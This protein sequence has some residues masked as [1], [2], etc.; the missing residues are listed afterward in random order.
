M[1]QSKV[2]YLRNAK[3]PIETPF[4]EKAWFKA[5][6]R[7][8]NAFIGGIPPLRRYVAKSIPYLSGR[9]PKLYREGKYIEALEL[10]LLGITKCAKNNVMN[11]W[12]WWSFMSYAVYCAYNLDNTNI[13][14]RLMTISE[15]GPEPIE[16][17]KVSYC[18]C[19][20]SHLKYT[21]EDYDSAIR[22]AELANKADDD[23]GEAYYLLGYYDLFINEKDPVDLFSAAIE[24]D[25]KIL[26][27]IVH[28]PSLKEFPGIIEEL[29]K[30]H[31]ITP[32]SP[33]E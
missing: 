11:H 9:V 31:V 26:S 25:P 13:M 15:K 27:R 23:S 30:L 17:S 32:K 29:K 16:D 7:L 12:W 21:Q 22:F 20:F 10:S 19:H 2:V 8:I 5:L 28:H 18:Y 4:C 6:S 24:R 14:N 33:N 3:A 1:D